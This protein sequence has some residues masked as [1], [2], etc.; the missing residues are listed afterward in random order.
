MK[1]HSIKDTNPKD[2]HLHVVCIALAVN[3]ENTLFSFGICRDIKQFQWALNIH[4]SHFYPNVRPDFWI[5]TLFL[6]S[7][8]TQCTEILYMDWHTQLKKTWRCKYHNDSTAIKVWLR[9][10][11]FILDISVQ[12][13]I[14]FIKGFYIL[15]AILY[16]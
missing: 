5:M 15:W 13:L 3:T 14:R 2:R 1:K 10:L 16:C 4:V 11:H 9:S 6:K 8:W 12:F 7:I